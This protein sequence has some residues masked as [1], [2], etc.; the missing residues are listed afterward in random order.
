MRTRLTE[1]LVLTLMALFAASCSVQKRTVFPGVHV[2]RM[3]KASQ[4]AQRHSPSPQNAETMTSLNCAMTSPAMPQRWIRVKTRLDVH[5]PPNM[6]MMPKVLPGRVDVNFEEPELHEP[7]PWEKEAKSQRL[8]GLVS[9]TSFCLGAI[10]MA[11]G[12]PNPLPFLLS[13]VALLMKKVQANKVLD[14]MKTHGVDVGKTRREHRQEQRRGSK[15]IWRTAI[16]TVLLTIAAL[17]LILAID[18]ALVFAVTL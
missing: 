1:F 9:L 7:Q 3:H 10:L 14:I 18:N 6:A 12:T 8:F 16:K 15:C 5:S 4:N 11:M 17:A 13:M 2:E